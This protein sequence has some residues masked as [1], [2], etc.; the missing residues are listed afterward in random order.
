MHRPSVART[1]LPQNDCLKGVIVL[2]QK[3]GSQSTGWFSQFN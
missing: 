1:N 2:T 3:G